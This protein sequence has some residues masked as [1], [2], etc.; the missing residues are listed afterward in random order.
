[1]AKT[2]I[3]LLQRWAGA[4]IEAM[5]IGKRCNAQGSAPMKTNRTTVRWAGIGIY[6]IPEAAHLL[7]TNKSRVRRW[8]LGY[9]FPTKSGPVGESPPIFAPQLPVLDKHWAIGFLDLVELLFIKAFRDEGVSLPTIRR[10]AKEA[11]RRW[12]TS[13]PF[14]LKR[15]ATDG[16]NIFATF[17]DE[18][19]EDVLLELTRSQYCF[20]SFLRPYLRQLEYDNLGGVDRWWPLGKAKPVCIDPQV[21]FGKPIVHPY[22]VPTETIYQAVEVN[23]SEMEVAEWYDLPV[24]VI[25]AAVEFEKTLAA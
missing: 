17:R 1:M 18:T 5:R 3:C 2:P 13:H 14:C 23:R 16:K 24:S 21:S 22:G 12:H 25:R 15:F 9:R 11:S 7:R 20:R 4:I 8:L 19:G 6:S 10:A